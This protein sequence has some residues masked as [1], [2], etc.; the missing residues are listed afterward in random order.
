MIYRGGTVVFY[1]FAVAAL[2]LGLGFAA[3][4]FL[5]RP[6]RAAKASPTERTAPAPADEAGGDSDQ[7]TGVSEGDRDELTGLA[8]GTELEQALDALCETDSDR[9]EPFSLALIDL[10]QFAR[11]NEQCGQAAADRVLRALGQLVAAECGG[12]ATASRYS[13]QRFVVLLEG[14][15]APHATG[16]VERIRQLIEVSRIRHKE[17]EIQV[18]VSCG[19]AER[20][21]DDLPESLISRATATLQEAK[22]YGRNRTFVFDNGYPV[23]VVHPSLSLEEK[24]FTV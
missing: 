13:G 22:R 9:T 4:V 20:A 23:P 17:E 15:D 19:V 24:S 2:N 12:R 16:V 8:T 3:A 14:S 21:V 1:A 10:D 18:T 7:E 5:A 6:S 11:V